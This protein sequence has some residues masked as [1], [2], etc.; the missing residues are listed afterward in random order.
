[1]SESQRAD[2]HKGSLGIGLCFFPP[3]LAPVGWFQPLFNLILEGCGFLVRST[4]KKSADSLRFFVLD[5]RPR[6]Q[7]FAQL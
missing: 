7:V 4:N 5:R 2:T 1:M 3:S 6:V